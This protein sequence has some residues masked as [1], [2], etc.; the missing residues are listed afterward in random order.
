[1]ANGFGILKRGHK[2]DSSNDQGNVP[3]RRYGP[4]KPIRG[5]LIP[6]RIEKRRK[7]ESKHPPSWLKNAKLV[8]D[9]GEK[10]F[11]YYV[12]RD[13]RKSVHITEALQGKV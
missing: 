13:K 12:T 1:M 4:R 3:G 2:I 8:V 7:N 9:E 5:D 6:D 10:G 11:L